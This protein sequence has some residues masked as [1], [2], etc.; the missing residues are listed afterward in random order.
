MKLTLNLAIKNLL[1][2]GLRTWLNVFILSL[3]FVV[4]LFYN[5]ML[6]GWS[7]DGIRDMIRSEVGY[8]QFWV[9]GY[10]KL[11]AYTFEEAHHTLP[12]AVQELIDKKEVSPMLIREASVYPQGRM[13]GAILKGMDLQQTILP[14]IPLQKL[15][16]SEEEYG[17]MLGRRMAD[18]LQVKEGETMLLRWRDINGAFDARSFTLVHIFDT[19][20]PPIDIGQLYLDIALLQEMAM[21]QNQ[22]TVLTVG[23]DFNAVDSIEGWEYKSLDDLLAYFYAGLKAERTSAMLTYFFL[24]LIGMLAIFD[25]QVL[26]VFH[27]TKEIGTYIALGMT[28]QQV[29]RLFT[30][31]GTMYSLLAVLLGAIWGTP[32]FLVINSV[33]INFGN[34]QMDGAGYAIPQVVYPYYS[35]WIVILGISSLVIASAIVSYIP[36]RKI[37]KL[38]PTDALRGK[39]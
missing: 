32:V 25:T 1:G 38:R 26:S 3:A 11:D 39:R 20:N 22:Y 33:G 27:R 19:D 4:M 6:E 17:L 18:H 15:A 31:E 10:D 30:V 37:A 29:M 16:E 28:R 34:M 35:P 36:A 2:A 24:L 5:G 9:Q 13:Q 7:R 8:G 21:L 12:A 14:D 23:E